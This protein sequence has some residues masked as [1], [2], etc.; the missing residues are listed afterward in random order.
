LLVVAASYFPFERVSPSY[1]SA[2]SDVITGKPPT[3]LQEE[4][5]DYCRE[6]ELSQKAGILGLKGR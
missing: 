1:H 4:T 6:I 3:I 2:V 5:E